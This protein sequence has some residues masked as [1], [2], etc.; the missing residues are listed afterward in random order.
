M[1][2][3]ALAVVAAVAMIFSAASVPSA[4]AHNGFPNYADLVSATKYQ[5]ND[6]LKTTVK[7]AAQVP[8]EPDNYIRS[9]LVY[10][11]GWVDIDT[12]KAFTTLLSIQTFTIQQITLTS[13]TDTLSR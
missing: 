9:V 12:G 10:G 3:P 7:A 6:A 1:L 8:K 13:G 4:R 5:A 2:W 11:Y